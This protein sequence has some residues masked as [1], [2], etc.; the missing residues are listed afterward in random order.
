M[1]PIKQPLA[2][3]PS[4]PVTPFAP[5][6]P[7]SLSHGLFTWAY[8]YPSLTPIRDSLES[9]AHHVVIAGPT[10]SGKT[11]LL[12]HFLMQ[13]ILWCEL[14][15]FDLKD[16]FWHFAATHPRVLIFH[17]QFPFVP[18]KVPS[19]LSRHEHSMI[20]ARTL[21]ETFFAAEHFLQVCLQGLERAYAD[22]DVPSIA[23]LGR[24]IGTL[25]SPK[26]TYQRRDAIDGARQRLHRLELRNPV[27]ASSRDGFGV[28]DLCERSLHLPVKYLTEV[29]EF[30]WNNLTTH[31]GIH[32]RAKNL[33]GGIRTALV[34]DE[35]AAL[36][37]S[38]AGKR[39]ITGAPLLLN[40]LLTARE[41]GNPYLVSTTT[42]SADDTLTTNCATHL[43]LPLATAEEAGI[44]K[45]RYGLN[46]EQALLLTRLPKGQFVLHLGGRW[47]T[48]MHAILP[49]IHIEKKV[50]PA[51]WEYAVFRT[52]E[53]AP[54]PAKITPSV[55]PPTPTTTTA[56]LPFPAKSPAPPKPSKTSETS[57]ALPTPMIALNANEKALLKAACSRLLPATIAYNKA[58]LGAQAGDRAKKKLVSLGLLTEERV[59]IRSGRG[60]SA[61]ALV[62]TPLAY[63]RLGIKRRKST[64]AG[65]S[66]QHRYLCETLAAFLP[67]SLIETKIGEKSVDLLLKVDPRKHQLLLDSLAILHGKPINVPPGSLLAIEVEVSH[68]LL[69][70]PPN[71]ERNHAA[72][73]AFTVLATFGQTSEQWQELRD[74]IPS[75]TRDYAA[76]VD[77]LQLLDHLRYLN[78]KGEDEKRP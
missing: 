64:R 60:G 43:I 22:H 25:A 52:N 49:P 53:R 33:R 48:P 62:P 37:G 34:M 68:P 21:A 12:Y 10:G 65:D 13:L 23:D 17:D 6:P 66:V 67:G 57:E 45:R 54:R 75:N 14:W 51:L 19:Y 55:N 5:V 39:H 44:A 31:L 7:G 28:E 61:N 56:P 38:H 71:V 74:L 50:S 35:G 41:F 18:L 32:H 20:F 76:V 70:G 47:P 36:W 3:L 9:V 73:V 72:G 16:D 40:Q 63:E 4:L 26:D 2:L 15:I 11:T 8:N 27:M 46:D 30:L 69:S 59:V 78:P 42:L 58:G 77:V 1:I 29:D 24:A